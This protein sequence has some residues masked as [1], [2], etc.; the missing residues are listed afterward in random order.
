MISR[1]AI[2]CRLKLLLM[3]GFNVAGMVAATAIINVLSLSPTRPSL[4]LASVGLAVSLVGLA[5]FVI[6]IAARLSFA[7]E[8]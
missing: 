4:V 5:L 8:A 3:C 7:R 1:H 6:A 2:G